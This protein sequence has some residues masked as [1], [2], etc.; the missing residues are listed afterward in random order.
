[1]G[2]QVIWAGPQGPSDS[3]EAGPSVRVVI[4]ASSSPMGRFSSASGNSAGR[5]EQQQQQQP[6]ARNS[7]SPPAKKSPHGSAA[8]LLRLDPPL[9][10]PVAAAGVQPRGLQPGSALLLQPPATASQTPILTE[11]TPRRHVRA[12]RSSCGRWVC[13]RARRSST[14]STGWTPRRWRWCPSLRS[15]SSSASPIRPRCI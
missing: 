9:R 6:P 2:R 14:T 7:P 1:M 8:A 13:R 5:R 4:W 11:R 12:G 3:R 10:R 15:P